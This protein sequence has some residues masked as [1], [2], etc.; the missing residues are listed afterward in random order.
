V[1]NAIIPK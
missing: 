1:Y